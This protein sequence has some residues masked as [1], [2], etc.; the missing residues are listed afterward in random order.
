[1]NK[2]D[3]ELIYLLEELNMGLF[4]KFANDG[5]VEAAAVA[6][7]EELKGSD[8]KSARNS[9]EDL[10]GVNMLSLEVV[11]EVCNKCIMLCK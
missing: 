9:F 11:T 8:P 7:V 2:C 10:S 4:S 1:M 5:C 3:Y 6:C